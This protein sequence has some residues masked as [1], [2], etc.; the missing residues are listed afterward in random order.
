MNEIGPQPVVEMAKKLGVEQDILAVPA[1]ALGT[2]DISVYEMVAAYSTFAN[3][4]VYNKPVMVT[5]IEDKNGTVLYQVT[6]ESK[7]VLSEEVAYVAVN[8][9][10]GVT[11]AGS[12]RRLRHKGF[13][14]WNAVYREIITG[15]PYELTNP[16]AGKTG[17]TQNQ[18]DGWFMGMVPNLVTGVWVGAEDRAAHFSR[19]DYGQ[20]ASMALPIWG[21]YMKACYADETLDVST[22]EFE[23]PSELTINV[24]CTALDEGDLGTKTDTTTEDE[25]VEIDFD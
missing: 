8:L 16:I 19:I 14:K 1:I 6:P 4:G 10:E 22:D 7:D 21:L 18:S 17:T 13:D 15:Y 23:E 9:M 20:G 12:G 2:A 24:D 5:R 3:K 25:E 11:Q